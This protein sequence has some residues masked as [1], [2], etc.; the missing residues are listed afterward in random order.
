MSDDGAIDRFL[1]GNRS[2]V[3]AESSCGEESFIRSRL[4]LGCL[5]YSVRKSSFTLLFVY[6]P[7]QFLASS[8]MNNSSNWDVDSW[9]ELTN[10]VW[11]TQCWSNWGCNNRA[12]ANIIAHNHNYPVANYDDRHSVEMSVSCGEEATTNSCFRSDAALV[13][14]WLQL[15]KDM[16]RVDLVWVAVMIIDSWKWKSCAIFY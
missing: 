15:P 14:G 4:W 12:L 16:Q 9:V 2:A 5:E 10:K 11:Q 7:V 6:A 1:D 13:N 8:W 3:V